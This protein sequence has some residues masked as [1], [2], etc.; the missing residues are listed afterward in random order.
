MHAIADDTLA[1]KCVNIIHKKESFFVDTPRRYRAG[2]D[3]VK[4]IS[5]VTCYFI[6]MMQ[7]IRFMYV[8]FT[9]LSL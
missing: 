1:D 6:Y 5:R 7:C 3:I 9:D 2:A 4:Y 8:C